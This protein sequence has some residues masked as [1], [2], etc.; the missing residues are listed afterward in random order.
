MKLCPLCRINK[1]DDCYNL[2]KRS[3]DGLHTYCRECN[4]LYGRENYQNNKER[5]F[6]VAKSRDKKLDLLINNVKNRPCMDCG[7]LY[8]HY[9]MDFDHRESMEKVFN[10]STM[11]RRRMGFD[12]II[13]E[14]EK[15]D[16]VC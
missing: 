10:I 7:I 1:D 8:P 3:K 5:Y 16:V 6:T 14:M 4:R 11:R 13:L 2:S 15:C 12:K 9:V